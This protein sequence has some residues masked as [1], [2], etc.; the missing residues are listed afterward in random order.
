MLLVVEQE[1]YCEGIEEGEGN[2][3]KESKGE[4]RIEN[5]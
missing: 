4:L 2:V 5:A 1:R 3:E